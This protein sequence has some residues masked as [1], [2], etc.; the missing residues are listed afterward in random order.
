LAAAGKNL[1]EDFN[2]A[3]IL[4]SLPETFDVLTQNIGLVKQ[5]QSEMITTQK[6]QSCPQSSGLAGNLDITK[7]LR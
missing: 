6:N 3:I 1:D 2:V 7:N 5:K 4:S